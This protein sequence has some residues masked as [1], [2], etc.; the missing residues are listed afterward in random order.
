MQSRRVIT[1]IARSQSRRGA[2][3][4]SDPQRGA[5]ARCHPCPAAAEQLLGMLR[6]L[7]ISVRKKPQDRYGVLSLL[8]MPKS[9]RVIGPVSWPV[10]RSPLSP[11]TCRRVRSSSTNG[12]PGVLANKNWLALSSSTWRLWRPSRM[13]G[14]SRQTS[15]WFFVLAKRRCRDRRENRISTRISNAWWPHYRTG[16]CMRGP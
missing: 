1:S 9:M 7:P 12:S 2:P 6:T 15:F 5:P 10:Q 3:G 4:G 14:P 13:P 8:L 11:E 16:S